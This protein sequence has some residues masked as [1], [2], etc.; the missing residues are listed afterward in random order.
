MLF[1]INGAELL[2]VLCLIR[3]IQSH[4]RILPDEVRKILSDNPQCPLS[5][6]DGQ[7]IIRYN[8]KERGSNDGKQTE[9]KVHRHRAMTMPSR[10]VQ[11]GW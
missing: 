6:I 1:T 3:L 8:G 7:K 11:F 9:K 10:R 2:F 5:H 4:T